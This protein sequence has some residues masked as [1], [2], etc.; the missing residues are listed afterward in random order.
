MLTTKLGRLGA[1]LS[2]I[3]VVVGGY[4]IYQQNSHQDHWRI[5][6]SICAFEP[7]TACAT[8]TAQANELFPPDWPT[9]TGLVLVGLAAVCSPTPGYSEENPANAA[10]RRPDPAG[11]A[12]HLRLP[13]GLGPAGAR[14]S[15][16]PDEGDAGA[17]PH[18]GNLRRICSLPGARVRPA[19]G[20]ADLPVRQERP[21]EAHAR[22]PRRRITSL[23][24]TH[25]H[26][27]LGAKRLRGLHDSRTRT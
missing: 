18:P 27:A 10:D 17:H 24:I 19:G 13:T 21:E 8:M 26:T 15:D 1:V 6:R 14:R 22:R 4:L 7:G 12:V 23:P 2:V 11:G 25:L 9:I 16:L 5:I 20:A 3:W